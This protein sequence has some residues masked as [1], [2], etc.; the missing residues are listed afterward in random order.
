[1][2]LSPHA[3]HMSRRDL[4]AAAA[5]CSLSF[6]LPPLTGRAAEERGPGRAKS[7]ITIWLEGGPSQLETWDPH[8][9]S[10]IGGPTK[11]IDTKLPGLQIGSD[12]PR[13][14]EE[15]Q[16]LNVIRSMVS[17]EGDHERGA[18][19]LKT[20]YR[21]DPT[22][23]HPSLGALLTRERPAEKI[24][25]PLYVAL[26]GGAFPGRG[27][28]FGDQYDPFQVFNPGSELHNMQ[29]NVDRK[30]LAEREKS[31]AVVEQSFARGRKVLARGTLHGETIAKARRMMD[32]DQLKAFKIDE[33]TAERKAAYG[34]T[35][36]GRG[37]LVARR[38]VETGVRAV[39]VNLAS[40]DTHAN[41]FEFHT[42]HAKTLD[43]AL[44]ALIQ[45]LR[46]RDLFASTMLLVIGEFGRTP[47]INPLDGRD[48]W[49]TGFSCL[50]GGGGLS[51]GRIIGATDP[52]GDKTQP[53]NPIS[54][55]DLFATVISQFG[56]S[57]AQEM[58]TPIGRPMKLSEG[59]PLEI[60]HA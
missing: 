32:S 58:T 59:K 29:P 55:Q 60:L 39:D 53:E 45:D 34:D 2:S 46:E 17:Q 8:P 38:L 44:A 37:C 57:P 3:L 54:V 31:L 16:H 51:A 9:G 43:P 33:E 5:G 4:L 12:Y 13:T 20:G 26:L 35:P 22:T 50:I 23:I 25:I 1:M 27:G 47:K 56:I 41:N 19:F 10:K 11:A 49:P 36:F 42:G 18:Y 30:R 28:Y 14:A 15:I 24:E 48:H 6:L 21:P 40:F 52:T 7:L